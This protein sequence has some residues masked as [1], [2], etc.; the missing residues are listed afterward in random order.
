M[1]PMTSSHPRKLFTLN[2][3]ELP[4]FRN[5]LGPGVDF[6]PLF[7]DTSNGIWCIRALF[8]PGIVLPS[9]LH[10]GPV[11]AYTLSGCW[12]YAEHPDQPQTAG[13]YLYEPAGT[14]P[15][16][17]RTPDNNTEVTE[18]IFTVFGA[19]VN[20]DANGNFHSLMDA[21]FIAGLVSSLARAQ[22]IDAPTFVRN[23]GATF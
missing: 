21:G 17:F 2:V 13:S 12:Y 20:F 10:T 1:N 9:H 4:V 14:A 11:H 16:L 3:N 22:G 5:A 8:G 6:Q 15:H 18:I 7:I 19:N 23:P